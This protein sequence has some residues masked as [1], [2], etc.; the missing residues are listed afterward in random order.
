MPPISALVE[1]HFP[2]GKLESRWTEKDGKKA[3]LLQRWTESGALFSEIEYVDG[4]PNGAIRQ[5]TEA[6]APTLLAT[7]SGGEFN[8]PYRS[9]WNT[10]QL[11]EE[12]VFANGRRVGRYVWY[13][14]DGSVWHS[15]VYPGTDEDL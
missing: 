13:R 4:V 14:E 8:G 9:W 1:N 7:V 3:G 10:G 2:S 11:K 15:E 5:W 6:G 12:G